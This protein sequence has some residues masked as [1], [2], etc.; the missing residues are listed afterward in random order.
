MIVSVAPLDTDWLYVVQL[1]ELDLRLST[2]ETAVAETPIALRLESPFI[3]E[4]SP[5]QIE[6]SVSPEST[7]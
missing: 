2:V 3:T 7:V 5:A 1:T 6:L 4:A